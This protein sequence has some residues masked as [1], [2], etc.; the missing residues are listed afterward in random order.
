MAKT[1]VKYA[2]FLTNTERLTETN[3]HLIYAEYYNGASQTERWR[4]E[5]EEAGYIFR[6]SQN[7][8]TFGHWQTLETCVKKGLDWG[9]RVYIAEEI[10]FANPEE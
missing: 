8:G 2:R 9:L 3:M 4:L 6:N 7:H 1:E 5:K 10:Q